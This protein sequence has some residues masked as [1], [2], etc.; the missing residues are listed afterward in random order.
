MEDTDVEFQIFQSTT[1]GH[2]YFLNRVPF[3]EKEKKNI[4]EVTFIYK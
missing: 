4:K 1:C 3:L 2:N